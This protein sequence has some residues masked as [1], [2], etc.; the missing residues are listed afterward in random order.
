MKYCG[1]IGTLEE[2]L[3]SNG[4]WS[5]NWSSAQRSSSVEERAD[6]AGRR[7]G[8]QHRP[9]RDFYRPYSLPCWNRAMYLLSRAVGKKKKKKKE[10]RILRLLNQAYCMI[11]PKG[12]VG[13]I[14]IP[15]P[16]RYTHYVV[17]FCS[18]H[19]LPFETWP[20]Y[21]ESSALERPIRTDTPICKAPLVTGDSRG[22]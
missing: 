22:G 12:D 5:P 18:E 10:R 20:K 13:D 15:C 8:V 3:T 6:L 11:N 21:P 16:E 4:T 9:S 7:C 1:C 2:C 17:L 14:Y 19:G